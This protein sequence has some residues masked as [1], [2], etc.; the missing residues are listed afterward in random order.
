MPVIRCPGCDRSLK[1][2][3][4]IKSKAVRCPCGQ[5]IGLDEA[6]TEPRSTVKAKPARPAPEDRPAVRNDGRR[7]TDEIEDDDDRPRRRP[8]KP[9]PIHGLIPLLIFTPVCGVL[10]I[11]APFYKIASQMTALAGTVVVIVAIV[12][13]YRRGKAKGLNE[14]LDAVPFYLRG[15]GSVF[16]YQVKFAFQFPRVLACWVFLE[17]FGIAVLVTGGVIF[18]NTNWAAKENPVKAPPPKVVEKVSGDSQ[19]DKLLF[20]L[21]DPGKS[22]GAANK[23]A[24]MKPDE[25]QAE[26]AARLAKLT[27]ADTNNFVRKAAIK[28]LGVWATPMEVPALVRCFGDFGA[29]SEAAAALRTVGPEA[30]DAVLPLLKRREVVQ[31]AIGVLKDIGTQK[32]VPDLQEIAATN[33]FLADPAR[34]ALAAIMARSRR[35]P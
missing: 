24:G 12:F 6:A 32:S 13:V 4:D 30:E 31:D 1:I 29:R 18:E 9:R 2:P 11:L 19:L 3:D 17:I 34:E 7:R 25:H 20:D 26:V 23:L 8:R 33:G 35:A 16:F 28:A 14:E 21:E 22:Q 15:G 27:T 10:L 5:K